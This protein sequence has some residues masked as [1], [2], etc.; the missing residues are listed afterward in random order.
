M[1][2][3]NS[4]L[5]YLTSLP[6]QN[7]IEPESQNSFTDHFAPV[8]SISG[9]TVTMQQPSWDNNNWGYDT[10]ASPFAGGGPQLETPADC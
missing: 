4:A 7:R 2:I 6:E 9:T 8:Q 5:N 10:L 3:V 1:N